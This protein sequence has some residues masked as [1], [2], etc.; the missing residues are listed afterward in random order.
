MGGDPGLA[1]APVP[2]L[3]L[4][5]RN[6][7]PP[8]LAQLAHYVLQAVC[9]MDG[10]NSSRACSFRCRGQFVSSVP[11]AGGML[12]RSRFDATR[13]WGWDEDW[14]SECCVQEVST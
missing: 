2:L 8:M 10:R 7:T 9:V 14:R 1:N 12:L 4:I 5:C 13:G 6:G 3:L 11:S